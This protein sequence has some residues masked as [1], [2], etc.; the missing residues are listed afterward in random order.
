MT[1]ISPIYTGSQKELLKQKIFSL[2]NKYNAKHS[3]AKYSY[4]NY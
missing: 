1:N 2:L 4:P 3:D